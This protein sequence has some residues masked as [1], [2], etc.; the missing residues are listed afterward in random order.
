MRS[1]ASIKCSRLPDV[2]RPATKPV[3]LAVPGEGVTILPTFAEVHKSPDGDAYRASASRARARRMGNAER[4]HDLVRSMAREG[5]EV[6][7]IA[8]ATG[9]RPSS[10][11][12]IIAKM[13][14]EGGRK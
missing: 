3:Q 11:R 10:I 14:R 13:R 6:E 5:A 4:R 2:Q 12:K 7:A 1:T 9:Y 8:E